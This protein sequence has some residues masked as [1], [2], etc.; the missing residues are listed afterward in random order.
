MDSTILIVPLAAVAAP[1]LAALVRR[2]LVVLVVPLIVFEIGLGML[3]GPNGLGWVANT[4]LLDTLSNLGLAC[5]LYT[6]RCV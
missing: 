1:L 2:V 5:L 6:S 4:E 3:V